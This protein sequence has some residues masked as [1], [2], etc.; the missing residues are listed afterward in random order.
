MKLN[1]RTFVL[2]FV[3]IVL[4]VLALGGFLMPETSLGEENLSII[5]LSNLRAY[6]AAEIAMSLFA[7]Y[8]LSNKKYQDMALTFILLTVIGWTVGQVASVFI[9]G[10]P[11]TLTVVS[12][13][14]Q[15][16]FIP[17]SWMALK[18]K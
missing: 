1:L 11:G 4:T 7:L 13:V 9:D 14:I 5:I 15:A 10:A 2:G 8:S 17:L 12:I 18:Q 16:A 3:G 6:T